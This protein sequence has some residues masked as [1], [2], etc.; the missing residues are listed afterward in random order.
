M[1][2][3]GESVVHAEEAA[4]ELELNSD[5]VPS[6]QERIGRNSHLPET[7]PDQPVYSGNNQPSTYLSLLSEL[8]SYTPYA[9]LH[10]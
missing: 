4:A 9:V 2:H 3:D 10:I 6:R 7:S 5:D 8:A 1:N